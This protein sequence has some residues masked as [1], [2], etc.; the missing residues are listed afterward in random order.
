MEK[1][2][3]YFLSDFDA[4]IN[5]KFRAMEDFVIYTMILRI[6]S[7]IVIVMMEWYLSYCKYVIYAKYQQG[8]INNII[9]SLKCYSIY[10]IKCYQTS[11]LFHVHYV[12][13][14][15]LFTI[16]NGT[17]HFTFNY[18]IS[19]KFISITLSLYKSNVNAVSFHKILSLIL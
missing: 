1:L 5:K 6:V 14:N 4:I 12:N 9:L 16:S 2:A 13:Q 7:L 19:N 10:G 17:S 3:L 11:S 18:N 15:E 8:E